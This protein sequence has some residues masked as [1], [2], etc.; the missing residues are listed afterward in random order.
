MLRDK[1]GSPLT[2]PPDESRKLSAISILPQTPPPL[3][4]RPSSLVPLHKYSLVGEEKGSPK[5]PLLL[6]PHPV[7]RRP[8]CPLPPIEAESTILSSTM[9]DSDPIPPPLPKKPPKPPHRGEFAALFLFHAFTTII[10]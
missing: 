2:P 1:L 10:F 4:E 6:P 5:F 8:P 3:P 7:S 9:A